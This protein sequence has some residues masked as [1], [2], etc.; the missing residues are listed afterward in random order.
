MTERYTIKTKIYLGMTEET[1]F[2]SK[3]RRAVLEGEIEDDGTTKSQILQKLRMTFVDFLLLNE[4][5][6]ADRKKVFGSKD[7]YNVTQDELDE[8]VE[9]LLWAAGEY[10]TDTNW[11]QVIDRIPDLSGFGAR[12]RLRWI[13]LTDQLDED[14]K[15]ERIKNTLGRSLK[16][17]PSTDSSS[18]V[19]VGAMRLIRFVYKGL[20]EQGMGSGEFATLLCYEIKRAEM[21]M[22]DQ[23]ELDHRI[24]VSI[25]IP[26]K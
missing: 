12:K 25:D 17:N 6:E 16:R 4:L 24:S 19:L 14:E 22:K 18:K 15:R 2:L 8:I 21:E 10:Q 3:R 1:G 11:R 26:E 20:R 9:Q 7:T 23:K 13:I 5:D